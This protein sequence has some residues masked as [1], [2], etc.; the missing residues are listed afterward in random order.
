MA[1]VIEQLH[2]AFPGVPVY[3]ALGNNDSDCGD[4]KLD[5]HSEFLAATGAEVTK[6]FPASERLAAQESFAA[7]G[8]YSVSLAAPMHNARLLVL[9]DLYMASKYAACAGKADSTAA[10][11]QLAWLVQKLEQ[12]RRNKEKVWV[13]GHIPPGVDLKATVTRMRGVCGGRSP[14]MFLSSEKMADELVAHSDVVE[15]GLFAHTH[16]DEIRLLKADAEVDDAA[17]GLAAQKS[18]AVKIVPSISPVDG[19][20]PAF[21]VAR[22]NPSSAAL[23][24]YRVFVASNKTGVDTAWR[25][26]YDYAK[27]YHEAAFTA[28]SVGKLIAGFQADPAANTAASRGYIENFIAGNPS[29]LLGLIWPQYTC[30]MS[31]YSAQAFRACMCAGAR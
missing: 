5:A 9:D 6:G 17:G 12:A 4:Y 20:N 28:A 24:D 31:N 21:M 2:G 16:M 3:V 14:E 18:V 15:L 10:D 13:M 7:G 26:E 30:I 29:P 22:V 27:T 1:F 11:A 8:Y 23:V 19:N 25:E